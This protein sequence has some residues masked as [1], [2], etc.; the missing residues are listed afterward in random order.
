MDR[1][2]GLRKNFSHMFWVQALLNV[3]LI[4]VVSTLFY[5]RRGLTLS[6]VLYTGIVFAVVNLVLEVPSSY[7]ADRWGRKPTLVLGLLIYLAGLVVWIIGHGFWPI[8][9]GF[10][11]IAASYACFTGTDDALVYDT[12]KELGEEK[13]TLR[14]LSR[15][16]AADRLFKIATP[17]IGALIAHS[18]SESQFVLLLSLDSVAVI[19]AIIIC[20]RI[21]EPHHYMDVEQ[22]ERGALHDAWH[23]IRSERRIIYAI[24]SRT[25]IFTSALILWRYHQVSFINMGISIVKLGLFWA[26]YNTA[27]FLLIRNIQWFLPEKSVSVRINVL[28][29][30]YTGFVGLFIVAW[31]W[32]PSPYVLLLIYGLLVLAEMTRWPL[33]SELFNKR[34][35]SY[36]RAT[37]LSL[38]NLLKSIL[39]I[40]LIFTAAIILKYNVIY[41]YGFA[42]L[43]GVVVLLFFRVKTFPSRQSEA[44]AK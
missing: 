21:I 29:G 20:L 11:C 39:D 1:I 34:S 40:P 16:Y 9:V 7:L 10:I 30:L 37:T 31:F 28:N 3:K 38:T 17:L 44:M 33:Y 13:T 8:I 24:L 35:L 26:V 15:Y 4:N 14:E 23:L 41:P 5:L 2:A 43:L 25:V 6:Q 42:F 32:L 36:N 18:L 12:A 27:S 19:A 22:Q